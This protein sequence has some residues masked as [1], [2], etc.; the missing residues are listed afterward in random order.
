MEPGLRRGAGLVKIQCAAV[1]ADY[2]EVGESL[3]P[4][5]TLTV[6]AVHHGQR[7]TVML[8]QDG[9]SGQ[10]RPARR[11]AA[12]RRAGGPAVK[13][14]VMFSGG[15]GSWAAA[16]RVA[17]LHGADNTVLMFADTL[18]EDEDLHRFLGEAAADIGAEL[19]H[20]ADGRDVWQVFFDERYLG[21]TRID[22]CSKILKRQLIRRWIVQHYAP[23]QA[24]VYLGIDWTEAHRFDKAIPYWQ[25]YTVAAPLCGAPYLD[26]GQVFAE[27]AAA[28]IQPPRLYEM[29]FPHN[30]CGGFCVKAGQGAFRLLLEKMPER[31]RHHE[32]REQDFRA[33]VGK[34]VAILR[35]RRGGTTRPL[36]M[37]EFRERLESDPA[38]EVDPFDLGGCACF[39]PDSYAADTDV[40]VGQR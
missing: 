12:H 2:L 29:G 32:Q 40:P 11:Q 23:D 18:T 17:A 10:P 15:V 6:T 21:N 31:Y 26:R 35:D 9:T 4:D 38:F 37:R 1:P 36:T 27:L 24:V 30:N 8:D 14:L 33:H 28:G 7:G 16:K 13:H 39:T 34:D 19:V 20:L 22:P 25:P 3:E 5:G